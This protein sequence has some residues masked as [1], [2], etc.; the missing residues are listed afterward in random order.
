M[1]VLA[2]PQLETPRLFTT[3]AAMLGQAVKH[4]IAPSGLRIRNLP[5]DKQG[6]LVMPDDMKDKLL[7]KRDRAGN[8]TMRPLWQHLCGMEPTNRHTA[9]FTNQKI[10]DWCAKV[11]YK[12]HEEGVFIEDVK[13]DKWDESRY[14]RWLISLEQAPREYSVQG[15]VKKE[16]YGRN[17]HPRS[18]QADGDAGCVMAG[19]LFRCM[20]DIMFHHFSHGHIKGE[21]KRKILPKQLLRA[22][23]TDA[24]LAA[25]GA[26]F[27]R[28]VEGDGSAWD[29]SC[30]HFIRGMLENPIMKHVG[31][32]LVRNGVLNQAWAE[33]HE[34]INAKKYT[35]VQVKKGS[36]DPV[37]RIIAYIIDAARRSGHRGTGSLNWGLD[38]WG[39]SVVV[40]KEPQNLMDTSITLHEDNWGALRTWRDVYE[41][42]D[43]KIT[44]AST[45][46]IKAHEQEI[47]NRWTQMGFNMKIIIHDPGE[48]GN[49][50]GCR[51]ATDRYGPTGEWCPDIARGLHV[52]STSWSTA[53]ID[54]WKQGDDQSV[55]ALLA[56]KN[57][58]RALGLANHA[59]LAAHLHF[60]IAEAHAERGGYADFTLEEK[61][62]VGDPSRDE[63]RAT[64]LNVSTAIETTATYDVLMR[65]GYGVT[66]EEV[67][68]LMGLSSANFLALDNQQLANLIP[69]SWQ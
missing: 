51:F 10:D 22:R 67:E 66:P 49:F 11:R 20:E 39:W 14:V 63:I 59:P 45:Q 55:H 68:R 16:H 46:D 4:R 37:T 53:A 15:A 64:M 13:S 47:E 42:D 33:A 19:V 58:A 32:R 23:H 8:W 34:R 28:V 17:K 24:E 36:E 44:T 5:K 30:S 18:L 25:L 3:S 48:P 60:Q 9:V 50:V 52:C 31:A 65:L 38:K 61:H 54:A 29:A 69:A 6:K 57:V 35:N 1:A 27:A 41:G 2:G 56:T 12:A 40:L 62:S 43:S 7:G 26:P 21:D